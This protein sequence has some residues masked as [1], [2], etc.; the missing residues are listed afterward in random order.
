MEHPY[1]LT[2]QGRNPNWNEIVRTMIY[3]EWTKILVNKSGIVVE[4][5]VGFTILFVKFLTSPV[6]PEKIL[7]FPCAIEADDHRTLFVVSSNDEN[8]IRVTDFFSAKRATLG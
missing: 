8:P 5:I 1:P 2:K 6:R 4:R 7:L 3:R